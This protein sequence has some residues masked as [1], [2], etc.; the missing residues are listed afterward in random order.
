MVLLQ[1]SVW[2]RLQGWSLFFIRH[3]LLIVRYYLKIISIFDRKKKKLKRKEKKKQCKK[4]KPTNLS[5]KTQQQQKQNNTKNKNAQYN[6]GNKIKYQDIG[7]Q[8]TYISKVSDLKYYRCCTK[9]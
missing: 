7:W 9:S 5:P 4:K 1:F 2:E 3:I 8:C 6:K